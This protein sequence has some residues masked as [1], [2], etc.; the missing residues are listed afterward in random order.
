MSQRVVAPTGTSL[1]SISRVRVR[2]IALVSDRIHRRNSV[3]E[4][5]GKRLTEIE[6]VFKPLRVFLLPRCVRQSEHVQRIA[7]LRVVNI[8]QNR[9]RNVPRAAAA[10][11][12]GDS[13]ILFAADAERYGET[14]HRCAEANLPEDF[15]GVHIDGAEVAVEVPD[16]GDASVG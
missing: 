12:R 3:A 10:E 9:S 8:G 11:A 13:D 15:S 2:Q 4:G 6:P 7:V 16:E 1:G 14:L 5:P